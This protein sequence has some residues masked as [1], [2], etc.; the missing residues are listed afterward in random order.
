MLN[1]ICHDV[2]VISWGVNI[3]L[4]LV[5]VRIWRGGEKI[6]PLHCQNERGRG[7]R[8]IVKIASINSGNCER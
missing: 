6:V 5:R 2:I 3:F 4:R 1:V 7:R 8:L